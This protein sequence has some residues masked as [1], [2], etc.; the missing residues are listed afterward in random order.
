MIE[1][2]SCP[3]EVVHH[4]TDVEARGAEAVSVQYIFS[5]KTLKHI[6]FSSCR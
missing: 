6:K 5:G 1:A 2:L 4:L 3:D